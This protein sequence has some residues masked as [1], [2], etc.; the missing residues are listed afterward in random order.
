[1]YTSMVDETNCNLGQVKL[2]QCSSLTKGKGIIDNSMQFIRIF[3]QQVSIHNNKVPELTYLSDQG[4]HSRR[5][6]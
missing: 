2:T 4:I 6:G 1:M 5:L 3:Q